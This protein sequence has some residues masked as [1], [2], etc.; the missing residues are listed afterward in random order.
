MIDIDIKDCLNELA[1]FIEQTNPQN[2]D[3]IYKYYKN[4]TPFGLQKVKNASEQEILYVWVE[5]NPEILEI[6]KSLPYFFNDRQR[7]ILPNHH[8]NELIEAIRNKAAEIGASQEEESEQGTFVNQDEEKE[9]PV[10]PQQPEQ[11]Q[12]IQLIHLTEINGLQ[13]FDLVQIE[14]ALR[15][16]SRFADALAQGDKNAVKIL[17]TVLRRLAEVNQYTESLGHW[18][19]RHQGEKAIFDPASDYN[20][21]GKNSKIVEFNKAAEEIRR[22]HSLLMNTYKNGLNRGDVNTITDAIEKFAEK[23][24]QLYI[25]DDN[26]VDISGNGEKSA[27][28]KPLKPMVKQDRYGAIKFGVG[29]ALCTAAIVSVIAFL[30]LAAFFPQLI[31]LGAL[32]TLDLSFVAPTLTYCLS[33]AGITLATSIAAGLAAGFGWYDRKAHQ[34]TRGAVSGVK[35]VLEDHYIE[36]MKS[37]EA[38]KT[39]ESDEV[40]ESNDD[41]NSKSLLKNTQSL[42]KVREINHNFEQNENSPIKIK[43]PN[44]EVVLYQF[45]I[46]ETRKAIMEKFENDDLTDE[47]KKTLNRFLNTLDERLTKFNHRTEKLAARLQIWQSKDD[48]YTNAANEIITAHKNLVLALQT[49]LRWIAQSQEQNEDERD[50]QVIPL[51]EQADYKKHKKEMIDAVK[52]AANNFDAAYQNAIDN[53][54]LY[55]D[56]NCVREQDQKVSFKTWG[57]GF[58]L[59]ALAIAATATFI[60][61][62]FF[63]LDAAYIAMLTIGSL[64]FGGIGFLAGGSIGGHLKAHEGARGATSEVRKTVMKS[65]KELSNALSEIEQLSPG[66]AAGAA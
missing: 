22:E 65:A 59:G 19:R 63:S 29:I 41:D 58:G 13:H 49:N 20:N 7:F 27:Y 24:H 61:L 18:L 21:N 8:K 1:N 36:L 44:N 55:E 45:D 5:K 3:V 52:E 54:L 47:S 46:I 15:Q 62:A 6:L 37:L 40:S 38:A 2:A 66:V 25:I 31:H 12:N 4:T 48:I 64:G 43:I 33:A 11:D 32:G 42:K 39:Y 35:H 26:S 53:G 34:R 14:K 56:D 9:V 50:M 51:L 60:P 57:I 10:A 17:N 16:N 30:P 28:S 23:Y